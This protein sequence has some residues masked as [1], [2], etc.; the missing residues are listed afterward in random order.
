MVELKDFVSAVRMVGKMVQKLVAKWVF[1]LVGWKD[2][3]L[4]LES[5]DLKAVHLVDWLVVP[6]AVL[7]DT[8]LAV[9]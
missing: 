3:M 4:A 7:M 6:M 2:C 8:N 9:L 5:V 1:W